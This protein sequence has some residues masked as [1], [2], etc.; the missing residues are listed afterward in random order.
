M[1]IAGLLPVNPLLIDRD[2]GRLNCARM[3]AT[4]IDEEA[5]IVEREASGLW[6]VWANKKTIRRPGL[7][8][9]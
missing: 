7:H 5:F 3:L 6:R 4:P 1:Q 8:W 2:W 9:G